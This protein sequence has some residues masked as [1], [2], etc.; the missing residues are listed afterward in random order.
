MST[1]DNSFLENL[2]PDL[3]NFTGDIIGS[4]NHCDSDAVF[5][6]TICTLA[7]IQIFAEIIG[8]ELFHG[9]MP[10]FAVSL[11]DRERYPGFMVRGGMKKDGSSTPPI[12]F[13]N[14]LHLRTKHPRESFNE[15]GKFMASIW[16]MDSCGVG[17]NSFGD[18]NS[19]YVQTLGDI[20][21]SSE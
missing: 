12:V 5:A 2:A 20:L 7:E 9:Q 6:Q 13:F 19:P 10:L 8:Q 16:A 15:M 11:S 18:P 1:F 14:H 17:P 21:S 3:L 4:E